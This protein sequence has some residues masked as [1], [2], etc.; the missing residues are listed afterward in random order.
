VLCCNSHGDLQVEWHNLRHVLSTEEGNGV[1]P[2]MQLSYCMMLP[3]AADLHQLLVGRRP[4][5]VPVTVCLQAAVLGI[6]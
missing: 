3:A 5:S 4:L 6:P 2:G 1:Q